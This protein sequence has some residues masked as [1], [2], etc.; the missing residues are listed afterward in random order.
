MKRFVFAAALATVFSGCGSDAVMMPDRQQL[1]IL[2]EPRFLQFE[3]QAYAAAPKEGSFWAV[4]GEERDL[5]LRYT[6]NGAAFLRFT[7]GPQSLASRPDGTAFEQG[8]S[9]LISVAVDAA[10]AMV[11]RFSPSGLKF[12]A[13]EPAELKL[14]HAR[15]NPDYNG[16]GGV[17]LLDSVASLQL[18]VWKQELP[19]LPWLKIPSLR[20]VNTVIKADIHDFTGFGMAVN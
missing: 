20:I 2:D 12:D 7:V 17:D 18:G 1:L 6:D 15:A 8:D 10:G 13:S 4:K 3:E 11:F 9:V 5:V 16:D 14:D 19:V